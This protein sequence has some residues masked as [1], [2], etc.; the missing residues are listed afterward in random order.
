MK[1]SIITAV[2]N[3]VDTVDAS[4]HSVSNQ[5]GEDIEHIV[6]DG[7]STDGTTLTLEAYR[8]QLAHLIVEPD[9][10]M[11]DALNKGLQHATGDIIGILNADDEYLDRYVLRDVVRAFEQN[12]SVDIVMT[13]IRLVDLGARTLR[14]ITVSKWSLSMLR[15]GWMPPHP[16]MFV[17][18]TVY[19]RIG[20]FSLNY[21]IAADFEFS[22]RAFHKFKCKFYKLRRFTVAM[23]DGGMSNAGINSKMIITKEMRRAC[24]END[25]STSTMILMMRFPFKF[26]VEVLWP[27][28]RNIFY[29]IFLKGVSM[30]R[31]D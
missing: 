19:E 6:V 15:F 9:Q 24:K 29:R 12:P 10:G 28:S 25:V 22:V 13:D 23:S 3:A 20:H 8:T 11:Y 27:R 21:E 5:L 18:R 2:F 30:L 14:E 16:G 26:F 4:L 7:C 17:R 1:I 31:A